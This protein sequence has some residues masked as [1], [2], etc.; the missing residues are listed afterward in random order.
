MCARCLRRSFMTTTQHQ[1]E[2]SALLARFREDM[3]GAMRTK[4]TQRLN[5]LRGILS[6]TTT[7]EKQSQSIQSNKDLYRLLSRRQK[8][9]IAAA[10]EF[11]AAGR[12]DLV[13]QENEQSSVLQE[14]LDTFD[15]M[16]TDD[17]VTNVSDLVDW[18]KSK[19][20]TPKIETVRKQLFEEGGKFHGKIVDDVLVTNK[21]NE[22]LKGAAQPR[23]KKGKTQ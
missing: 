7:L 23:S 6:E 11:Q 2:A 5:T 19:G 21:I 8:A 9:C 3:K 1:A 22:L 18:M 20:A 14:Y 13:D 17:T 15:V 4:D 12:E 10:K 16:S